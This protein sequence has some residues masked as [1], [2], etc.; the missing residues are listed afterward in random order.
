MPDAWLSQT[1]RSLDDTVR[2]GDLA[3]PMREI[4]RKVKF[5]L[6]GK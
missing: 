6:T 3:L 5:E 4:Y 2:L 1:Y